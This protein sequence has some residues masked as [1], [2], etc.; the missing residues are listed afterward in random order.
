ME[1]WKKFKEKNTIDNFKKTTKINLVNWTGRC[2]DRIFKLSR[3]QN[4]IHLWEDSKTMRYFE[5]LNFSL[6]WHF[7]FDKKG[8][9]LTFESRHCTRIKCKQTKIFWTISLKDRLKL[10]KAERKTV[11]IQAEALADSLKRFM[12][13]DTHLKEAKIEILQ[14]KISNCKVHD[15]SEL[16]SK[17]RKNIFFVSSFA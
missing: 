11:D 5:K 16:G 2:D 9:K 14:Q 15:S 10:V 4:P 7:F 12:N 3:T 1:I 8:A 6:Q 17:Q 13:Q